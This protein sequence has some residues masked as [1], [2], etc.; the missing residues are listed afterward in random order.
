MNFNASGERHAMQGVDVV[1]C[2][3]REI[4][5]HIKPQRR[6]PGEQIF[7]AT[8]PGNRY[9]AGVRIAEPESSLNR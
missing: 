5:R 8:S 3:E 9:R 2:R 4:V 7:Y 6:M 1:A